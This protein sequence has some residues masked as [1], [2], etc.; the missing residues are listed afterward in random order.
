MQ[1]MKAQISDIHRILTGNGHPENGL[2]FKVALHGKHVNFM[3]KF[4]GWILAGAVGLPFTVLSGVL[5][6][7]LNH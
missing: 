1:E 4:G 3:E 7:K 2:V 5:I 6:F